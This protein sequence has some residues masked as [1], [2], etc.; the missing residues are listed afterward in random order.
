MSF[1][2]P[3]VLAKIKSAAFAI[4]FVA[5]SILF[6]P[7]HDL[8]AASRTTG[9]GFQGLQSTVA[10]GLGVPH[11]TALDSAGNLYVTD[12]INSKVLRIPR[13]A[14]SANCT[15]AGSCTQIGSGFTQPTGVAV[16]ASGNAFVT[17]A[18]TQ[19]LYKVSPSGTQTV[20][21]TGLPGVSGV[22]LA[23]DGTAWL[24]V[25]GNVERLSPAGVLSTFATAPAQTGGIAIATDGSVYLADIAGGTVLR[26]TPA[27]VQTTL[28]SGLSSPQS[29]ALDGAGNLYISDAGN[30]RILSVPASGTGYVCPADCAVLALQV[31][32]PGGIASDASGQLYVADTGSQRLIKLTQDADFGVAP[33]VA[34]NANPSSALTLNYLLYSSSCGSLPTVNVLTRGAANKD[35]TY[36]PSTSICTPGS[37]DSLAITVNF[38][39][40]SPG[41]RTGSVQFLDATGTPQV[42]TYL[43]G[44]GKGPLITWTPG[45]VTTAVA[46][47][48]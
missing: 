43:H 46:S 10:I 19:N 14:L 45:V 33:V 48:Q 18:S 16:D 8:L 36:V 37:P 42:A 38:A 41:L 11:G 12:L 21:A 6:P 22:A 27:A 35:F 30:N 39:P 17:D 23:A 24:A 20:L 32:A 15:V 5:A 25:A 47:P 44:L 28:V 2:S 26:Y 29:V 40:L 34:S 9:V 7:A 4:S 13:G 1:L 31:N 3:R